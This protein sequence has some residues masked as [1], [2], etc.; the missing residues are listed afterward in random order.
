MN[1]KKIFSILL[2]IVA[3]NLYGQSSPNKYFD[4]IQLKY[5]KK[6]QTLKVER[7]DF[8]K[9]YFTFKFKKVNDSLQLTPGDE[10]SLLKVINR[11][12]IYKPINKE[13]VFKKVFDSVSSVILTIQNQA[14]I[15]YTEPP[16]PPGPIVI[17]DTIKYLI[18]LTAFQALLI[19][20]LLYWNSKLLEIK[21]RIQKKQNADFTVELVALLDKYFE[22]E[23]L[24]I[25]SK[26][27]DSDK[28]IEGLAKK[29]K[30]LKLKVESVEES[31]KNTGKYLKEKEDQIKIQSEIISKNEEKLE[32]YKNEQNAL[33]EQEKVRINTLCLKMVERKD[34]FAKKLNKFEGNLDLATRELVQFS[35]AYSEMA[36][37]VFDE[38]RGRNTESGKVNINMLNGDKVSFK[39]TFDQHTP[40]NAIDGEYILVA[41]ILT[42]LGI[43]SIEDVYFNGD[44]FQQK[45]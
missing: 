44:K 28:L 7:I 34:L 33:Q 39:N 14:D 8:N 1:L 25:D 35:F 41:K 22:K 21:R 45:K 16:P 43:D 10:D 36:V 37:A 5:D 18:F 32:N 2:I 29:L 23:D 30:E 12:P 19:L 26:I 24:N 13:E 38:I 6:Q 40:D 11:F 4:T 17:D 15:P 3:I 31:L 27:I 9:K 42:R 20:M